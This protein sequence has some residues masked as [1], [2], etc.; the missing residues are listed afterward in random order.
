M[1][2]DDPL[3]LKLSKSF[4]YKTNKIRVKIVNSV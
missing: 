3:R 2:I 1:E 4:F